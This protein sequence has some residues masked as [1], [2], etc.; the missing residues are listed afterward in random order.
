MRTPLIRAILN[1]S[2]VDGY[3]LIPLALIT[4]MTCANLE[5]FLFRTYVLLSISTFFSLISFLGGCERLLE[6]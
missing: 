5:K 6:L 3:M 4:S 2:A 1:T